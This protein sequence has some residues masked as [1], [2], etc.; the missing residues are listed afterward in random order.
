MDQPTWKKISF[1]CPFV[2]IKHI[3]CK[4]II[5]SFHFTA[6]FCC[7][8]HT[9]TVISSRHHL[10]RG[11]SY[12]PFKLLPSI[13]R[14]V[15]NGRLTVKLHEMHT[16]KWNVRQS[17]VKWKSQRTVKRKIR[18]P[19]GAPPPFSPLGLVRSFLRPP[20]NDMVRTISPG[21]SITSFRMKINAIYRD[22]SARN[23]KGMGRTDIGRKGID[24]LFSNRTINDVGIISWEMSDICRHREI[25]G[26]TLALS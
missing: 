19:R 13:I 23:V 9:F 7:F 8:A 2:C 5:S 4:C 21:Q 26:G 6:S 25:Y 3:P 20:L 15:I 12:L 18:L 14:L 17:R 24:H 22:E 1:N 11:I 16:K 10:L